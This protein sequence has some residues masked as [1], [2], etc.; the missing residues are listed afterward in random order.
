MSTVKGFC[1]AEKVELR[2]NNGR[3]VANFDLCVAEGAQY[4]DQQGNY[5]NRNGWKPMFV[6]VELWGQR[7]KVEPM[8]E[9]LTKGTLVAVT[10]DLGIKTHEYNGQTYNNPAI[11]AYKVERLVKAT[12]AQ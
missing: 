6:R 12:P 10:G 9:G 11:M 4:K 1:Q 2:E 8:V 5:Q 3:V 7:E